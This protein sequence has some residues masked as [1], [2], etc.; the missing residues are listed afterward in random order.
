MV[1]ADTKSRPLY[2]PSRSGNS[3]FLDLSEYNFNESVSIGFS[4][5]NIFSFYFDLLDVGY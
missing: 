2:F 1:V 3:C 5:M 4:S